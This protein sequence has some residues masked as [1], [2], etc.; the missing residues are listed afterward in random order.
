ME[1]QRY[2]QCCDLQPLFKA[3][4]TVFFIFGSSH[5]EQPI[6]SIEQI[7]YYSKI[8]PTLPYLYVINISDPNL[9]DLKIMNQ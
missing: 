4:T 8:E 6:I 7:D 2:C 1:D 9:V 5:K 3:F